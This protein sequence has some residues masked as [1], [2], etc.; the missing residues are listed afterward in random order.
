VDYRSWAC[1]SQVLM[2]LF[3]CRLH[4]RF[5]GRR[6]WRKIARDMEGEYER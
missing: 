1:G 2:G 5:W 6:Y 4:W 3:V